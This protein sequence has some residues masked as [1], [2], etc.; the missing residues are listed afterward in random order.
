MISLPGRANSQQTRSSRC[1][2]AIVNTSV[3]EWRM[4]WVVAGPG[5]RQMSIVLWLKIL[6]MSRVRHEEKF[7]VNTVPY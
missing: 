7:S 5:Y 4:R 3:I 2:Y 6:V 1:D